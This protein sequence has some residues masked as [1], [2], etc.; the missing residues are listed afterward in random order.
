MKS[1]IIYLLSILL[2][3]F[4]VVVEGAVAEQDIPAME[5]ALLTAL[6]EVDNSLS[7]TYDEVI[8]TIVSPAEC[9]G[10]DG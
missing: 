9:I 8:V 3:T 1:I 2:I 6:L 4:Q 5:A 7:T 10:M